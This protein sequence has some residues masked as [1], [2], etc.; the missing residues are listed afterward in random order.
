MLFAPHPPRPQNLTPPHPTGQLTLWDRDIL[1]VN[2]NSLSEQYVGG[3]TIMRLRPTCFQ[4]G[5]GLLSK[6]S[7]TQK[8]ISHIGLTEL[9]GWID[10]EGL[11]SLSVIPVSC[12]RPAKG[13]KKES[14]AGS[15][16]TP[17]ASQPCR[18]PH[19]FIIH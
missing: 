9:G 17:A 16:G 19:Q 12:A 13:R 10:S 18:R 14:K 5:L 6:S 1:A 7:I 3:G 8:A 4:L 11:L 2:G 15:D